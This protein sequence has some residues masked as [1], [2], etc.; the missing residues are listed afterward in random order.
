MGYWRSCDYDVGGG[1][2]MQLEDY[3]E[4]EK[5]DSPYGPFDRIRIKGHRIAIERVLE[6]HKQGL[7][8]EEIVRTHYP[9]LELR[10]VYATILY[11]LHNKQA[12]E[13]YLQRGREVDD[14]YYQE[15]LRNH[16][17][18]PVEERLRKLRAEAVAPKLESA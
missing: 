9:S 11:Y 1:R 12:V 10:E 2:A 18:S 14:Q 5:F 13:G 17:P 15:W 4:F 16:K 3:F 7:S 8:P 6:F